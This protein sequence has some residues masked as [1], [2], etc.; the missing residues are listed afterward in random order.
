[1]E[2]LGSGDNSTGEDGSGAEFPSSKGETFH[3]YVLSFAY[4]ILVVSLVWVSGKP[5]ISFDCFFFLYVPNLSG[6]IW[7]KQNGILLS[8][9]AKELVFSRVRGCSQFCV[10]LN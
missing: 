6:S 1:M 4:G 7:R 5:E 9:D 2:N 10:T 3:I 8:G